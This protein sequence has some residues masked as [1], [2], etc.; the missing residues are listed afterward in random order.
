MDAK[1]LPDAYIKHR[2]RNEELRG[3]NWELLRQRAEANGLYF[4]PLGLNPSRTHAVLWVA[5]E[6]LA[7]EPRPFDSRFLSIADP[8]RDPRLKNWTGFTVTR[9]AGASG[10]PVELI[11]LALYGLEYPKVPLLLV[12]FRDTRA[13]KHREMM[14]RAVTDTLGGVLGIS[15]WG[16]WPYLA[17]SASWNFLRERHGDPNDR[18]ARLKAY[19]AVRQWL[20]LDHSVDPELRREL[21]KRLEVLGVNPLVESVFDEA[22]I[23]RR[24]YDALLRLVRDPEGLAVRLEKDRHSEVVAY[25]HGWKA[26][27]GLQLASLVTLGI[28]RHRDQESA[29]LIARLTRDR[30]QNTEDR[31]RKAEEGSLD[32]E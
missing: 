21:Q 2:T 30:E 18:R 5:R 32:S 31:R 14:R 8:Y 13:P 9:P 27:A 29:A 25:Q 24:Q 19:S 22:E 4:E 11:P 17:G 26:R 28:Y 16:N 15:K 6:D 23:A 3:H 7:G 1:K 10:R 20:A 12:D